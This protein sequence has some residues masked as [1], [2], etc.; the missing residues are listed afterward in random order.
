MEFPANL[1]LTLQ[2]HTILNGVRNV[3]GYETVRSTLAA[4]TS[5]IY[6]LDIADHTHEKTDLVL[7][8]KKYSGQPVVDLAPTLNFSA[9]TLQAFGRMSTSSYLFTRSQRESYNITDTV[10]IRVQ[11]GPNDCAFEF[12]ATLSADGF[13]VVSDGEVEVS[14]VSGK[15]VDNF[16]Y[17]YHVEVQEGSTPEA[18][19]ADLK[20][21][22]L[23]GK[24]LF[25]VTRCRSLEKNVDLGCLVTDLD[26]YNH[27]KDHLPLVVG[28]YQ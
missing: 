13:V 19:K 12:V 25:N 8:M 26:Q 3:S 1:E 17:Y 5:R 2:S 9:K 15:D 20:I 6:R 21:Q 16:L 27:I 14:S 18:A 28:H 7:R 24:V 22:S 11:A 10:Y 4:N 23:R